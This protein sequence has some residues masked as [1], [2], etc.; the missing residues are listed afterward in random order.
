MTDAAYPKLKTV[1]DVSKRLGWDAAVNGALTSV[2]ANFWPVN[3]I[4][5]VVTDALYEGLRKGLDVSV[6]YGVNL[7]AL[8]DHD[9]ETIRLWLI[10]QEKGFDS[11]EFKAA[12]LEAANALGKLTRFG[13]T[14]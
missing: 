4:A 3:L 5:R 7:L 12:N 11:P 6:I 10:S 1:E 13:A 14:L 9:R 8:K 2:G